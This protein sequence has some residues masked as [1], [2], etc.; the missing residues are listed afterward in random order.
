MRLRHK[1]RSR[2]GQSVVEFALILP[3]IMFL[4]LGMIEMGFAINHNSSLVTATRQG[5]RVGSELVDGTNHKGSSLSSLASKG[6]DTQIIAAVQGI[7]VSS[8]SPVDI[9]QVQ[10][11]Q[12]F[13][14]DPTTGA[15][16]ISVNTWTPSYD[17]ITHAPSGPEIP[18]SNCSPT[19]CLLSFS[20][21]THKWNAETRS[22]VSTAQ[23]IGVRI[24]YT[25]KFLTPLGSLIKALG[26][27]LFGNGQITMSDQTIMAMEPP[28]P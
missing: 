20:E 9:S 5:A 10:T 2:R 12:I 6:V 7:L 16:T 8:G 14:A 3:V 27:S 11:I 25:Y 13:L 18:G 26:G 21:D 17:P 28:T 1:F 15:M 4:L 22:G 19:K 24:T 23:S